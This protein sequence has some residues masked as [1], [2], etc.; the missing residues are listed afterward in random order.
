MA[1]PDLHRTAATFA[2][3]LAFHCVRNSALED[4]HA[5]I[6]PSSQTGDYTDV[7]VVSPYG[8][9]AWNRVGRISDEE[10]KRLSEDITSCKFFGDSVR[11]CGSLLGEPQLLP[12]LIEFDHFEDAKGFAACRTPTHPLVLLACPN[13]PIDPFFHPPTANGFARPLAAAVIDDLRLM[14]LEVCD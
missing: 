8:E 1:T 10:M 4:L 11:L 12:L 6:F 9:I 2:T 13:D 5:G 14:L 3:M 7:K